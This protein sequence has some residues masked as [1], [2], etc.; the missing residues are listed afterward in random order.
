MKAQFQFAD[1]DL[2]V[3][4]N[5]L[6]GVKKMSGRG[7]LS[8]SLEAAGTNPFALASS[9]DGSASL[10]AQDG[11]IAGLNVENLLRRL[12][13]RPLSGAGNFRNGQTPFST[14]LM[15]LKFSDGTATVEDMRLDGPTAKLQ[16]SGTASVPQR[17][18]DLKGVAS[19]AG[20][21]PGFELPFVIQGPWDEPLIFPD[22]ESLLRRSPASAPLLDAMKDRKAKDAVRSVLERITGKTA[23]PPEPETGA[24]TAP[25]PPAAEA[26]PTPKVE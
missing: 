16:I 19:L 25:P 9:L 21:N 1:V 8:V 24:I 3:C 4:S 20:A 7:T 11:A 22:P 26:A 2:Q 13:R 17:E 5:E 15:N 18:Y 6:L 14:L 10:T 23:P 12:E